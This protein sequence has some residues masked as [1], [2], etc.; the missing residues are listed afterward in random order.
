[1]TV[2]HAG[3]QALAAERSSVPPGHVRGGPGLVDE[4]VAGLRLTGL[5]APFV[6]DGPINRD[7]FEVYVEKVLVPELRLGDVVVM[8]NLSSHQRLDPS[9]APYDA[10]LSIPAPTPKAPGMT[11]EPAV[12]ARPSVDVEATG[13]V[14]SGRDRLQRD[15]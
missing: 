5:V 4:D 8:D 2:R 11:D 10:P 3:P 9:F 6:L 1:M 7:A 12:A 13:S 14:A 15:Q